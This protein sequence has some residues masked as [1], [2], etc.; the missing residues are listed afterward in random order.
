VKKD[1]LK[2]V[3][4][5]TRGYRLPI[6]AGL[7]LLVAELVISFISPLIMSVTIDSVLGSRPLT[8]P[9][10]FAWIITALGGLETIKRNIWIMA[11]AIVAFQLI[12]GVIRYF[13]A[14]CNNVSG[15]GI[16][17]TM[18]DKLYTHIQRLPYAWH[19][20][21]QTGDIIQRATSDVETVRRFFNTMMLELIRTIVMLF[22][23]IF[24]MFTISVQLTLITVVLVIPVVLVS[25]L[26]FNKISK[27]ATAQEEAEGKLFTVIQENLTGTRVV[28]A[29]GRQSYEMEK[30]D[31]KN[32]EN[33]KKT[34]T[35]IRSFATL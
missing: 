29:F 33:R 28:R 2:A 3:L 13:R 1:N 19:A 14:Q 17:K 32:E 5:Y 7:L 25:V 10:Y 26:F 9:W 35:V 34:L 15:E 8:A 18:R 11:A 24:V 30:F 21:A 16:V 6:I 4:H 22:V 23:G 27:L 12:L 20:N 31:E